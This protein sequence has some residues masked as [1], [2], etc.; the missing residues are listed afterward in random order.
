M[1]SETDTIGGNGAAV[2]KARVDRRVEKLEAISEITAAIDEFKAEDKADGYDEKLIADAVRMR[3]KNPQKVYAV[4]E[5]EAK[6]VAYR[7]AAGIETDLK[8]AAAAAQAFVDSQ[9]EAKPRKGK[10]KDAWE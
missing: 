2:F 10:R 7:K 5:A 3:L 9:P 8:K 1:S 4:L 6:R